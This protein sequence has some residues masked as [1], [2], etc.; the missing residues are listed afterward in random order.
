[1]SALVA[2]DLAKNVI[3]PA[4]WIYGES[5]SVIGTVARLATW[6]EGLAAVFIISALL[7]IPYIAMQLF[8]PDI[9]SRDTWTRLACQGLILGGVLWVYM[10]YLSRNLDYDVVTPLFAFNGVMSIV[11]AGILG[12]GINQ[13]QIENEDR[14]NK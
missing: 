14:A 9:P 10:A 3:S 2:I 8:N 12:Y 5:T 7:I 13:N 1:M 11:M 4:L 6:P